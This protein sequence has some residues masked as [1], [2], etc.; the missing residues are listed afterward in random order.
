MYWTI[1]SDK[2]K[3][4]NYVHMYAYQLFTYS[5]ADMSSFDD[6]TFQLNLNNL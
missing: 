1:M 2:K 4:P 3:D 5:A 6:F